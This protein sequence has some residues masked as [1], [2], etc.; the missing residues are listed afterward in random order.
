MNAIFVL[1]SLYVLIY[2]NNCNATAAVE[3]TITL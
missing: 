2:V 3:E 1:T